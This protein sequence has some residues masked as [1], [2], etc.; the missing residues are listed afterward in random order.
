MDEKTIDYVGS[1]EF[2]NPERWY[3]DGPKE[4]SAMGGSE[5]GV[6]SPYIRSV[7]EKLT[8]EAFGA[9]GVK[10]LISNA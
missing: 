3:Y 10:R 6:A 9:E 8:R 1:E 4:P 2:N 7:M 5:G